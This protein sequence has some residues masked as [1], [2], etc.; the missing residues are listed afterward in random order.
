M[1]QHRLRPYQ[2]LLFQHLGYKQ[3]E[4][5]TGKYRGIPVARDGTLAVLEVFWVAIVILTS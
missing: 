5:A 1:N 3:E 4:I 2:L